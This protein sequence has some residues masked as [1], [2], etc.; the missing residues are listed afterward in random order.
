MNNLSTENVLDTGSTDSRGNM[1][2]GEGELEETI[3]P[4]SLDLL[5]KYQ[6]RLQE[7]TPSNPMILYRANGRKGSGLDIGQYRY[8]LEGID[9][10]LVNREEYEDNSFVLG[11]E[12][13]LTHFTKMQWL[14]EDV[15]EDSEPDYD[16]FDNETQMQ[17]M[18][19][20]SKALSSIID[21]TESILDLIG[22]ERQQTGNYT[23]YI[24]YPFVEGVFNEKETHFRAPLFLFPVTA[25]VD[26]TGVTLTHNMDLEI[27]LNKTLFL[28]FE[29]YADIKD[30]NIPESVESL[31]E[32]GINESDEIEDYLTMLD[33]FA[34]IPQGIDLTMFEGVWKYKKDEFPYSYKESNAD[35]LEDK[36]KRP[37]IQ[38]KPYIV[39]SSFKAL[40]SIS[41]DFEKLKT[42]EKEKGLLTD[43]RSVGVLLGSRV[44]NNPFSD[45]G[46]EI[47]EL[48]VKNTNFKEREMALIN[49]LDTS[50]ELAVWSASQDK[51]ITIF[52][53]PG[54]GKS[55]V[56][57]NI[58][59][60]NVHK[61]KSILMV[62]QKKTAL[63]VV[64]NRLGVLNSKALLLASDLSKKKEFYEQVKAEIKKVLDYQPKNA[65]SFLT[66]QNN[67]LDSI[68]NNIE[69]KLDS[70]QE[71]HYALTNKENDIG[72]SI[73]ALYHKATKLTDELSSLYTRDKEFSY[74]ANSKNYSEL[75][76]MLERLENDRITTSYEVV[77]QYENHA[78]L[79]EITK[80]KV[81]DV[82]NIQ[83]DLR[84]M[85]DINKELEGVINQLRNTFSRYTNMSEEDAE[86]LLDKVTKQSLS[87]NLSKGYVQGLV[88]QEVSKAVDNL[89]GYS[90]NT[91]NPMTIEFK[92]LTGKVY[93]PVKNS[94]VYSNLVDIYDKEKVLN[95]TLAYDMAV[96]ARTH[97]YEKSL[98]DMLSMKNDLQK[99]LTDSPVLKDIEELVNGKL[100]P[101]L[102]SD[103]ALLGVEKNSDIPEDKAIEKYL[104]HLE[105][106]SKAELEE[107]KRQMSIV[108]NSNAHSPNSYVLKY[109]EGEVISIE[110]IPDYA[111][112]EQLY[113][114][115]VRDIKYYL[116]AIQDSTNG[117][118]EDMKE[119]L[120]Y[121]K[122]MVQQ[123]GNSHLTAYELPMLLDELTSRGIQIVDNPIKDDSIYHDY[124]E[125]YDADDRVRIS[126]EEYI[127]NK[128]RNNKITLELEEKEKELAKF[129]IIGKQKLKDELMALKADYIQLKEKYGAVYT[130]ITQRNTEY[131]KFK[132]ICDSIKKG[133][134]LKAQSEL[135][136][137]EDDYK[138]HMLMIKERAKEVVNELQRFDIFSNR[139]EKA[140]EDYLGV[141]N[142]EV[143]KIIA[144]L[145]T[146]SSILYKE[147][148]TRI[149]TNHSIYQAY[150]KLQANTSNLDKDIAK[151]EKYIMDVK[152][153]LKSELKQVEYIFVNNLK[154]KEEFDNFLQ[155]KVNR[156]EENRTDLVSKATHI[157][158]NA[159]ESNKVKVDTYTKLE[160]TLIFQG[161]G[162]LGVL[163]KNE[164]HQGKV[165]KGYEN[166]HRLLT[167]FLENSYDYY[168][169]ERLGT[170][171]KAMLHYYSVLRNSVEGDS[172][173]KS[174]VFEIAKAKGLLKE[175]VTLETLELSATIL[176]EVIK[177]QYLN[178][179]V[180][181]LKEQYGEELKHQVDFKQI[182][183][184]VDE[185][186]EEKESKVAQD[187]LDKINKRGK[188][189][190]LS[191]KHEARF[192]S[193][194]KEV[195]LSISSTKSIRN[196]IKLYFEELKI[197]FPIFL[198]TPENVSQVLPLEKEIFDKVLFDEASQMFVERAI[199]SAYR[200]KT[201]IVAGDDKQLKPTDTTNSRFDNYDESDNEDTDINDIV[202][203]TSESLLD[204]AKIN[205]AT[206]NLLY[207]YRS[208]YN[209][210][211]TFSN[212]AFYNR[213]LKL[214]PNTNRTGGSTKPLERIKVEGH[215]EN[216]TNKPESNAVAELIKELI[217]NKEESGKEDTI[218]VIAFS[219]KQVTEIENS[220]QSLRNK[221]NDFNRL[222]LKEMS[223][224][225]KGEDISIFIKSIE[226]VQG[227][228][229]DT[230]ILS[231]GYDVN[232]SG[233]FPSQ[234]G[235]LSREGGEN[236]LNVAIT[237]SKQKMYLVTSFE[238]EVMKQA[239]TPYSNAGP[240]LLRDFCYY[241]KAM[242]DGDKETAEGVLETLCPLPTGDEEK[243][244]N[245][246][247]IFEEQVYT[248]LRLNGFD[249]ETQVG[250]NGYRLDLAVYDAEQGR[251]LAGIECDGATYHSSTSA[252]ERDIYRQK[253][254]ESKGWTILRIWSSDW[255]YN[256][257]R[258]IERIIKELEKL[259][260]I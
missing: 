201:I 238:P 55:Q 196:F 79:D 83:L 17:I 36:L 42:G 67:D 11:R 39:Y 134:L 229:R 25:T 65:V 163:K 216:Q 76:D 241:M 60:N 48:S 126:K 80:Y 230:I 82:K 15:P 250:V 122:D 13:F 109:L 245:F 161:T 6:D 183:E 20:T 9:E 72:L 140:K 123:L 219:K 50:Q 119:R 75:S 235:Y 136:R 52:G 166:L 71:L 252:R 84:T 173:L 222:Y 66:T 185:L 148:K 228:E 107:I 94:I 174:E 131:H 225:D 108:Q 234:F 24:G 167:E 114:T 175:G 157:L 32:L 51:D 31:K 68:S 5:H 251:Y 14:Q 113:T 104:S 179:N 231:T 260:N 239:N 258:E 111:L 202:A 26:R 81:Q 221:D 193:M 244:L 198:L 73:S 69:G 259:K 105:E 37:I 178:D 138:G 87:E 47:P 139:Y 12:D 118:I 172:V 30:T 249:V 34:Y 213:T 45:T 106:E 233:K 77:S 56:M 38:I 3:K 91:V 70:L 180:Y 194:Q 254:L 2:A 181:K 170:D 226:D 257:N 132:A 165:V 223:R 227:D 23:S 256:S 99:E 150:F 22:K 8:G 186:R 177:Q 135:S 129:R 103:L 44:T 133:L 171:T 116:K 190:L 159:L 232:E 211:I 210:L 207:H 27:R 29:K 236:R 162:L 115:G 169:I 62:S 200:G 154:I 4:L 74:I 151:L 145:D 146:P 220:I 218:G 46:E 203:N 110:N 89:K 247:S 101:F 1:L 217:L 53:P 215:W 142:S 155:E 152:T 209:E 184:D 59:S 199:P 164:V 49:Q 182:V 61:G 120:Y 88:S 40:T 224:V 19:L 54:T 10:W 153:E 192:T 64:Y 58:I 35:A 97:D 18:R 141:K 78:I 100:Q 149:N 168:E 28:G 255:W 214:A 98:S 212:Y 57:S 21:D 16:L 90:Y 124:K 191:K 176:I 41:Q 127:S 187:I 93:K 147:I 144:H 117:A 63:D 243:V 188:S 96:H 121:L 143:T 7:V 160:S 240:N 248:Q 92:A 130:D 33:N 189:L 112:V 43:S 158:L 137:V 237:R 86:L 197:L 125:I 206:T 102:P 253:F 204:M 208:R 85:M 205:M 242:S 246:D 95:S 195:Q 156:L 128:L